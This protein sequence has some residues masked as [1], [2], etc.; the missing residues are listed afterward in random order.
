MNL[1]KSFSQYVRCLCVD[2]FLGACM[3]FSFFTMAGEQVET[4]EQY[5]TELPVKW[6]KQRA[7]FTAAT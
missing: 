1:S 6:T 4:L 7:I 5:F 3:Y 2:G